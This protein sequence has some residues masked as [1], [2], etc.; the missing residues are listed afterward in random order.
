MGG[1]KPVGPRPVGGRTRFVSA[2]K[3][4]FARS[5]TLGLP[6]KVLPAGNGANWAAKF[7]P[8]GTTYVFVN[9]VVAPRYVAR[10][11]LGSAG[12]KTLRETSIE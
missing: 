9:V 12:L 2:F 3:S 10:L 7:T 4:G 8:R 5:A 1:E 6:R 11:R